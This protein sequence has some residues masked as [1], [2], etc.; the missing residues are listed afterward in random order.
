MQGW[1][2]A[3][4][5]LTFDHIRR[6]GDPGRHVVRI[7]HDANRSQ[8]RRVLPT[9]QHPHVRSN[10]GHSVGGPDN[11]QQNSGDIRTDDPVLEQLLGHRTA[12]LTPDSNT[13][14]RVICGGVFVFPMPPNLDTDPG[15]F[16]RPKMRTKARHSRT[17]SAHEFVRKKERTHH[18]IS[19][20]YTLR[21]LVYK[22]MI[23]R[24]TKPKREL[25]AGDT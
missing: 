17:Q 25:W 4:Q 21:W 12:P 16:Q 19:R 2:N 6:L 11:G 22:R 3:Q 13:P 10:F 1:C 9:I 5:F 18:K 8:R 15:R 24:I 20:T 7:D 23:R 14:P